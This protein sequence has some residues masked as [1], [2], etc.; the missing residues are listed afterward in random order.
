MASKGPSFFMNV[1]EN[2]YTKC[3]NRCLNNIL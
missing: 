3:L 1:I 2:L